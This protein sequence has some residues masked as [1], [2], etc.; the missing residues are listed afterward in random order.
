MPLW[1]FWWL[2]QSTTAALA[3][4]LAQAGPAH[5]ISGDLGVFPL[6]DVPGH[7]LGPASPP[8]SPLS[9]R[10]GDALGASFPVLLV[11]LLLM[12]LQLPQAK[13]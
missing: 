3:D 10:W 4:P 1:R 7:H 8:F 13:V 6:G 12:H 9:E 5:Q 2:Y 11:H